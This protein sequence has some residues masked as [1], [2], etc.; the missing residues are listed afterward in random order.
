MLEFADLVTWAV[1]LIAFIGG[2]LIVNFFANRMKATPPLATND[3]QPVESAAGE[4][5]G[6]APAH[7]SF[8]S[9][10]KPLALSEEQKCAQILGVSRPVV[11]SEVKAA[12]HDLLVKYDPGQAGHRGEEFRQLAE[13]KTQ[14][15]EQA[16]QYFQRKYGIT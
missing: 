9:D 2:Y 6:H 12:Y 4:A 14:E 5:A 16:Y 1:I 15:I 11:A 13:K 7:E 3:R 8:S 10:Q